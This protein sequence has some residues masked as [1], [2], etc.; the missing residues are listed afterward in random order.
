M[1]YIVSWFYW[2]YFILSADETFPD[3]NAV[4]AAVMAEL[5]KAHTDET[6]ETVKSCKRLFWFQPATT[7]RGLLP[8][9]LDKWDEAY[10]QKIPPY[11]DMRQCDPTDTKWRQSWKKYANAMILEMTRLGEASSYVKLPTRAASRLRYFLFFMADYHNATIFPMTS[12]LHDITQSFNRSREAFCDVCTVYPFLPVQRD[13]FTGE[14]I[15]R[16]LARRLATTSPVKLSQP[17]P[18]VSR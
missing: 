2:F 14:V 12:F 6:N 9:I 1:S 15:A 10:T 4:K 7:L 11:E 17:V 13:N 3:D 18:A 5:A 8:G 16:R